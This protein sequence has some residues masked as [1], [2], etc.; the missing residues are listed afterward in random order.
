MKIITESVILIISALCFISILYGI[1]LLMPACKTYPMQHMRC[2]VQA[3][4]NTTIEQ[5]CIV[6][7]IYN[8]KA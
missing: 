8:E 3:N 4:S 1:Y 2:L 6:L 7:G 5:E